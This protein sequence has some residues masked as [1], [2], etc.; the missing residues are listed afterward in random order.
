L[1]YP[2]PALIIAFKLTAAFKNF[3]STSVELLVIAIS[4]SLI[5]SNSAVLSIFAA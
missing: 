1:S 4:A 3:S 2:T 5:T